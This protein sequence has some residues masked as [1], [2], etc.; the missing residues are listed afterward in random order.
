[1]MTFIVIIIIKIINISKHNNKHNN[2]IINT[3]IIFWKTLRCSRHLLDSFSL[4]SIQLRDIYNIKQNIAMFP[5]V[6]TT[7]IVLYLEIFDAFKAF[8]LFDNKYL[9][10]FLHGDTFTT[11]HDR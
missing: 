7:K 6:D 5:L 11:T 1:M 4:I 3:I 9:D 10:M 8:A 2:T